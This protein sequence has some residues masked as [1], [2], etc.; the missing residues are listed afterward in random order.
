MLYV[1]LD[2]DVDVTPWIKWRTYI[3]LKSNKMAIYGTK[4]YLLDW[5]SA[6]CES[7]VSYICFVFHCL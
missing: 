6:K 7:Y 2:N 5:F 4:H 1:C 3:Q